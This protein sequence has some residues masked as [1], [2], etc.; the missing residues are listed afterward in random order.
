MK[1]I[2]AWVFACPIRIRSNKHGS[3]L[4]SSLPNLGKTLATQTVQ[5]P[6][7]TLTLSSLLQINFLKNFWMLRFEEI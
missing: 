1:A 2:P 3:C 7:A 6:K 4:R 5:N